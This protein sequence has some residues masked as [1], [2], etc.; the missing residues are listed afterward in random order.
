MKSN[1]KRSRT[2]VNEES[3][4]ASRSKVEESAH[5]TGEDEQVEEGVAARMARR[6]IMPTPEEI[7]QHNLSHVPSQKWCPHRV[8]GRGKAKP[9]IRRSTEREVPVIGLEFF[10]FVKG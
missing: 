9:H 4:V 7:R 10:Y 1:K 8:A 5:C 3:G 6:K 2:E